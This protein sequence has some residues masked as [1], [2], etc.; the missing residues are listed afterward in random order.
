MKVWYIVRKNYAE[1]FILINYWILFNHKY[2][3]LIITRHK[4]N[5]KRYDPKKLLISS[6]RE[7]N[8]NSALEF[9]P[10]SSF[11]VEDSRIKIRNYGSLVW[12]V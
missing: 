1:G 10:T 12:N 5:R 2:C 8:S 3:S 11:Y 6:N 4:R 7:F 9:S